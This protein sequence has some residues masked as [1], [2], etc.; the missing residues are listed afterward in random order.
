MA[1][2]SR[3][4]IEATPAPGDSRFVRIPQPT[5]RSPDL[6]YLRSAIQGPTADFVQAYH[7]WL[8]QLAMQHA[9]VLSARAKP[10][11]PF[12]PER[13]IMP[14]LLREDRWL[15]P[16]Q[17]ADYGDGLVRLRPDVNP[18]YFEVTSSGCPANLGPFEDALSR[19]Y[20]N[21]RT[22]PLVLAINEYMADFTAALD[23]PKVIELHDERVSFTPRPWSE[24][25]QDENG[26]KVEAKPS[27]K[28]SIAGYL[29]AFGLLAAGLAGLYYYTEPLVGR[30]A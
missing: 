29:V 14:Y 27:A 26:D 15:A 18:W 16:N 11:R 7:S 24:A 23:A 17:Q 20:Q 12:D 30:R 10:S 22:T 5:W 8:D 2:L 1:G 25:P 13:A 9:E 6:C 21:F 3:L 19:L 28:K 4:P